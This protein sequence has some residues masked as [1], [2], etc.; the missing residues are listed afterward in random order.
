VVFND[1]RWEAQQSH[2]SQTGQEPGV[3]PSLWAGPIPC[4]ALPWLPDTRYTADSLT[5]LDNRLWRALQ[6]HTSRNAPGWEPPAAPALWRVVPP[7]QSFVPGA[8][9]VAAINEGFR[10]VAQTYTASAA[11]RLR[12]VSINVVSS[13]QFRL[14]VTVRGVT[15]GVPNGTVLGEARLAFGGVALDQVI[16]FFNNIPQVAGQQYA[17]VVDYPAAPPAGA[18]NGQG[19]WQGRTGNSYPAGQAAFSNNGQSWTAE[20]D[21]DLQF[22][23]FVQSD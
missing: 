11:G 8:N 6:A 7:D 13:S 5:T 18:G 23:T 15:N 12:G 2:T 4:G 20:G 9:A 17:I 19:N 1:R 3:A 21:L 16:A 22:R 14:H 10:F